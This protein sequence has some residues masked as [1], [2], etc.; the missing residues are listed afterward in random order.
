MEGLSEEQRESIQ[1]AVKN[2]SPEMGKMVW[3]TLPQAIYCSPRPVK[4]CFENRCPKIP[5]QGSRKSFRLCCGYANKSRVHLFRHWLFPLPGIEI[6]NLIAPRLL[7]PHA[8]S[9]PG[10]LAAWLKG[11]VVTF[12]V[13]GPHTAPVKCCCKELSSIMKLLYTFVARHVRLGRS[14]H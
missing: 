1:E 14:D 8:L 9:W 2:M 11:V 5:R 10:Q 3:Q 12:T 4:P 6:D 13:L 7:V